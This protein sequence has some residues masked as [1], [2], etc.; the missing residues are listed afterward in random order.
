MDVNK[1]WDF[2]CFH[3]FYY[4]SF[5]ALLFYGFFA[6][7][8]YRQQHGTV[9]MLPVAAREPEA[10]SPFPNVRSLATVTR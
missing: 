7:E 5:L 2:P 9:S 10:P 4:F 8:T 1:R 6:A 3:M